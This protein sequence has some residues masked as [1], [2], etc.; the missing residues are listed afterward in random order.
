[1]KKTRKLLATVMAIAMIVAA[2][3]MTALAGTGAVE[4]GEVET[5][6]IPEG[7]STQFLFVPDV[8]SEYVVVSTADDNSGIDPYIEIYDADGEMIA[9][10]D[11]KD[12]ASTLNFFC[13]FE[14]EAG[15]EYYLYLSDVDGCEVEYDFYISPYFS[16]E[17]Q[18]TADEP[19][20]SISSE[21]TDFTYQWFR[22]NTLYEITDEEAVGREGLPGEYAYYN[23]ECGWVGVYN[24][25]D[26][27]EGYYEYNFF[28]IELEAGQTIA[29][30]ADEYAYEFG[31]W[32]ESED[33]DCCQYWYDLDAGE[34]V[35]FTAEEDDVYNVY[36]AFEVLP[37]LVAEVVEYEY[38]EDE[39]EDYLS[40]TEDGRYF[41]EVTMDSMW[42]EYSD[43]MTIISPCDHMCHSDGIMGFFWRII[44]FF[45]FLFGLEPVCYC[46][47]WHY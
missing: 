35:Y 12:N 33:F 34:T 40:T 22:I 41:C 25:Y 18:P 29:M 26:Y 37:W 9:C 2:I 16:I 42:T 27:A 31:I 13:V 20:V 14:A 7:E 10:N 1:M 28:T 46:G 44:N 23:A 32:N 4:I 3:P 30:T 21:R 17:H 38:I 45:N 11:D 47:E 6:Y 43:I 36:G 15:E 8:T 5:A 19:Y 24:G 39:T